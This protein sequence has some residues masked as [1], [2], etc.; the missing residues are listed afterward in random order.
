MKKLKVLFD[1]D[2]LR[3]LFAGPLRVKLTVSASMAPSC[4]V[5]TPWATAPSSTARRS[6]STTRSASP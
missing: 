3:A 1:R 4:T 6:I 5:S 2:A